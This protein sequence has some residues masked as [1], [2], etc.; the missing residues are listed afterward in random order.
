M[1]E[2]LLG[3]EEG[4]FGWAHRALA[5]G[6]GLWGLRDITGLP[7]L[8]QNWDSPQ[9]PP[10]PSSSH[11]KKGETLQG[12]G[13]LSARHLVVCPAPFATTGDR[14]EDEQALQPFLLKLKLELGAQA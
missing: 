11:Q 2:P 14:T 13:V 9:G 8:P 3:R 4:A 7:G 5:L 10:H 6:K 12:R 1:A